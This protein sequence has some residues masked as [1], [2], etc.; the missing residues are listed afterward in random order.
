MDRLDVKVKMPKEAYELEQGIVKFVA[1]CKAALDDG[2]QPG[3]DLPVLLTAAIASLMPAIDGVH[4][5]PEEV[6]G[7]IPAMIGLGGLLAADLA[8]I[9]IKVKP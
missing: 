1:A 3:Q 4:K 7:D 8:A 6:L 2:F 9:F 5:L